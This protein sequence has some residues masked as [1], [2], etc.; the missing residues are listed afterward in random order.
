MHVAHVDLIGTG[1]HTLGDSMTARYDE[2]IARYIKLFNRERHQWQIRPVALFRLRQLLDERGRD[3]LPA[4]PC[5]L[6]HEVH[7]AEKIGVGETHDD[8]FK[9]LLGACKSNK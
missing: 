6:F 3:R 1:E 9:Y 7:D 4:H 8:L 2:V 5:A